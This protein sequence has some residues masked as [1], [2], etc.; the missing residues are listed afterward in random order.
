MGCID[1]DT[2]RYELDKLDAQ[3]TNIVL[4]NKICLNFVLVRHVIGDVIFHGIIGFVIF[5]ITDR[6]VALV[7]IVICP[8]LIR[9]IA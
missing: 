5:S 4:L 1:C 9:S 2:K 8:T 3:Q 6:I 7:I